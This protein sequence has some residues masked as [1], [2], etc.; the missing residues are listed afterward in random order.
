MRA[1]QLGVT[2]STLEVT[3]DSESDDRGLLGM[4]DTI[5][6]GP[7]NVRARVRIGASGVNTRTPKGN[8]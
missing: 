2:L 4:D 6:A 5:S 7:L 1:A 3:V 8:S